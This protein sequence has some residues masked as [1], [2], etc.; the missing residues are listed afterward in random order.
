MTATGSIA[1]RDGVSRIEAQEV[2]VSI[3]E[4]ME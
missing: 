2:V 3:A 1:H 4:E